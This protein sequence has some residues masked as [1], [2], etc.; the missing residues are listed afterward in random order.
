MEI[1][2][3]QHERDAIGRVITQTAIYLQVRE[4]ARPIITM[5]INDFEKFGLTMDE[6]VSAYARARLDRRVRS[7]P[8]PAVILEMVRPE[9]SP[10]SVVS[11][12]IGRITSAIS[13]FGYCNEAEARVFIGELGLVIVDRMGGW[14]QVCRTYGVEY[15][16]GAFFAQA[17]KIA[18]AEYE[19][20][21]AGRRNEIPELPG[22]AHEKVLQLLKPK[23]MP[24]SPDGEGA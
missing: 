12:A 7:L 20:A 23:S 5:Y 13:K 16:H 15:D 2:Y 19:F 21:K 9:V 11:V 1:Q 10:E 22:P 18:H 24:G 17:S 8:I 4:P 6:I 14:S 3:T